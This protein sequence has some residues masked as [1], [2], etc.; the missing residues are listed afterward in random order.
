MQNASFCRFVSP[1]LPGESRTSGPN[2]DSLFG[3]LLIYGLLGYIAQRVSQNFK[4]IRIPGR[5]RRS[6]R[7]PGR[8]LRLVGASPTRSRSHAS[9]WPC[10]GRTAGRGRAAGRGSRARHRGGWPG[11]A[12]VS[13]SRLAGASPRSTWSRSRLHASRATRVGVDLVE[14]ALARIA[15]AAVARGDRG[16][17][18]AGRRR[19]TRS[20]LAATPARRQP[21]LGVGAGRVARRGPRARRSAAAPRHRAS[22]PRRGVHLSGVRSGN[23]GDRYAPNW[24]CSFAKEKDGRI[25]GPASRGDG[26][27]LGGDA[28]EPDRYRAPDPRSGRADR[29]SSAHA[30]PGRRVHQHDRQPRRRRRAQ[31]RGSTREGE[32]RGERRGLEQLDLPA[33]AEPQLADPLLRAVDQPQR[34][35]RRQVAVADGERRGEH[36]AGDRPAA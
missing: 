14:V 19:A 17:G 33:E 35:E 11:R 26:R 34:G 27:P 12:A 31:G 22:G 25:V 15:V 20:A 23:I 30:A 29:P 10:G 7:R 13:Y 8:L 28:N 5:A 9:R 16:G 32:A 1:S 21:G 24:G 4:G 36:E 6:R 18:P 2:L 3:F